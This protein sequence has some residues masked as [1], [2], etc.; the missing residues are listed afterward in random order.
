[1]KTRC[2]DEM[3]VLADRIAGLEPEVGSGHRPSERG[4]Y[5]LYTAVHMASV[6]QFRLQQPKFTRLF[7]CRS[8]AVQLYTRRSL[9][10]KEEE[11]K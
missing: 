6:Q 5:T 3:G 9:P 11:K 2:P 10:G 7:S 8:T 1:M 4:V